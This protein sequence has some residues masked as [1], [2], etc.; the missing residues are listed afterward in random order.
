MAPRTVL[1]ALLVA[2][3]LAGGAATPWLLAR[4]RTWLGEAAALRGQ[5]APAEAAVDSLVG[6]T[7]SVRATLVTARIRAAS[8]AEATLHLELQRDSG[9][10]LLVRD[11]LELRRMRIRVDGAPPERGVRTLAQLTEVV[12]DSVV[13]VDSLGATV[14]DSVRVPRTVDRVRLDDG[15]ELRAG[16]VADVLAPAAMVADTTAVSDSPR[17]ITD[18]A[19][20]ARLS[21]G[22]S[23]AIVLSR[24]DLA[25][26]RPNL[27]AGMK[28]FTW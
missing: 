25:A 22:P 20:L 1:L 24:R 28:V 2:A 15:V 13:T 27:V 19:A 9:V 12:P 7:D 4:E 5:R 16:D 3:G 26:I 10:L 8:R 6:L 17:T 23:R 21:A 18:G 14:R 11:G